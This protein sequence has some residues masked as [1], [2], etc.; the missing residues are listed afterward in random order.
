VRDFYVGLNWDIKS[1]VFIQF[2]TIWQWF[3]ESSPKE[4]DSHSDINYR[5]RVGVAF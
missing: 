4:N 2:A 1:G 3:D 5:A